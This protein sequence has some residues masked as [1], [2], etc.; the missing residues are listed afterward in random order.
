LS[1]ETCAIAGP[2]PGS[3]V[4]DEHLR[5]DPVGLLRRHVQQRL[6]ANAQPDR[7]DARHAELIEHREDVG[8]RLPKCEHPRRVRRAPMAAQVGDDEVEA[9]GIAGGEHQRPV[10]A[11]A[12]AAVEEE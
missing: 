8:R 10:S 12:G 7:L 3:G 5:V 11:D 4:A 9:G 1:T 2:A 6:G